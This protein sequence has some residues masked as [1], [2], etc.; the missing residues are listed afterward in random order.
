MHAKA[1]TAASFHCISHAISFHTPPHYHCIQA[2]VVVND[3]FVP[4][5]VAYMAD[6]EEEMERQVGSS[7]A[8]IGSSSHFWSPLSLTLLYI[9]LMPAG[10]DLR[11]R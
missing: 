11:E 9:F 1:H 3:N 6:V 10:P 4:V 5:G 8:P 7:C 2:A